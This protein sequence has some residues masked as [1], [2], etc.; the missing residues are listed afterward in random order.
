MAAGGGAPRGDRLSPDPL[1]G[2]N[3]AAAILPDLRNLAKSAG[4]HSVQFL[5]RFLPR[6]TEGLEAL[7]SRGGSF[8]LQDVVCAYIVVLD[9]LEDKQWGLSRQKRIGILTQCVKGIDQLIQ[10]GLITQR[11]FDVSIGAAGMSRSGSQSPTGAGNPLANAVIDTLTAQLQDLRHAPAQK[12]LIECLGH[13][14]SHAACAATGHHL[15]RAFQALFLAH[16]LDPDQDVRHKALATI[17]SAIETGLLLRVDLAVAAAAAPPPAAAAAAPLPEP[18]SGSRAVQRSATSP[19]S[20]ASSPAIA[21][22]ERPPPPAGAWGAT[23]AAPPPALAARGAHKKPPPPPLAGIP[24]TLPKPGLCSPG[25]DPSTHPPSPAVAGSVK[26]QQWPSVSQAPA[27]SAREPQFVRLPSAMT[28]TGRAAGEKELLE[29]LPAPLSDLYGLM[30]RMASEGSK[31]ISNEQSEDSDRVRARVAALRT[32]LFILDCP[33]RGRGLGSS[34]ELVSLVKYHGQLLLCVSLNLCTCRPPQLFECAVRIFSCLM[35]KYGRFLRHELGTLMM[36]LVLPILRS[37]YCGFDQRALLLTAIKR[38]LGDAQLV[39]ELFLNHD[40][41]D[42]GEPMLQYTLGAAALVASMNYTAEGCATPHQA[43]VLQ[44]RAA[45]VLEVCLDSVR[46]WVYDSSMSARPAPAADDPRRFRQAKVNR[47]LLRRARLA[48]YRGWKQGLEALEACGYLPASRD[49]VTVARFC[50]FEAP[51][52][53]FCPQTT[54]LLLGTVRKDFNEYT[55]LAYMGLL[56]FSGLT[57]DQGLKKLFKY[58]MPPGEGALVEPMVQIFVAHYVRDNPHL[59]FVQGR[60]LTSSVSV[61][62]LPEQ[63]GAQEHQRPQQGQGAGGPAV[64]R[65]PPRIGT[66]VGDCGDPPQEGWVAVRPDYLVHADRP[67]PS[68]DENAAAAQ[69]GTEGGHRWMDPARLRNLDLAFLFAFSLVMLHTSL[70]NPS[71]EDRNRQSKEDFVKQMKCAMKH[72]AEPGGGGLAGGLPDSF[73]EDT[74]DR[75]AKERWQTEDLVNGHGAWCCKED[76]CIRLWEE[77]REQLQAVQKM[78]LQERRL[79]PALAGEVSTPRRHKGMAADAER[80]VKELCAADAKWREAQRKV[81]ILLPNQLEAQ[82]PGLTGRDSHR[83]P[84]LFELRANFL[85]D[86]QR[87]A[88]QALAAALHCPPQ[89]AYTYW[90]QVSNPR[91]AEVI[92][93]VLWPY[94]L[95]AFTAVLESSCCADLARRLSEALVGAAE[96]GASFGL[97]TQLVVKASAEAERQVERLA[98]LHG[99]SRFPPRAVSPAAFAGLAAL[100]LF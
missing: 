68:G 51:R 36:G 92:L 3:L 20:V 66:V 57:V 81:E 37:P 56:D 93:E 12:L 48:W 70:Y 85:R 75:I 84:A 50:L 71:F 73:L 11:I 53:G 19:P 91:H 45:E 100:H 60:C 6:V 8:P 89:R 49:P 21:G 40:G 74:Y 24:Q 39:I 95:F 65:P 44:Q 27:L 5:A 18:H 15:Q 82:G 55:G 31:D 9:K 62:I 32:L 47:E 25:P 96:L 23:R 94:C 72:F 88:G 17:E 30:K 16:I 98:E 43:I 46:R 61:L 38:L 78:A 34:N 28:Q 87:M 42:D 7:T 29:R 83:T 41:S 22:G 97:D 14:C 33:A 35:Q 10:A 63:Q 59:E 13:V 80:A 64:P 67:R 69:A 79:P 2:Q 52:L 54:G 86:A 4:K 99:L 76:K 90:D 1:E 77:R 58:F 26:G